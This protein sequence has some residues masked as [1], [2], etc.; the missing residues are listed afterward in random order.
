MNNKK[1]LIFSKN[2]KKVSYHSHIKWFDRNISN[3]KVFMFV[4]FFL[5]KK[6]GIVRFN[7]NRR[8]TL[9]SINLNP[10]MRGKNLS[11]KLLVLSI[12]KFLKKKKSISLLAKIHE[13]NIASI[14]CF[15][16]SGFLFYKFE[17][18][19]QIYKLN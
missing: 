10:K 19:F 2:S 14:K 9:V 17:K 3:P 11:S 7:I 12:K 15:I 18:T 8:N 6:V 16:K 4:G 13:D 1:S 5:R